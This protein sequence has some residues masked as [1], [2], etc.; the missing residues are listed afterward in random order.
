MSLDRRHVMSPNRKQ[1]R[2]QVREYINPAFRGSNHAAPSGYITKPKGAFM[3]SGSRR[4]MTWPTFSGVAVLLATLLVGA[5]GAK[6]DPKP[7]V[8]GP[9]GG[10]PKGWNAANEWALA[11]NYAET[12]SDPPLCPGLFGAAS[13]GDACRKIMLFQ[14]TNGRF[15]AQDLKGI[16]AVVAVEAPAGEPIVPG[17]R[18]AWRRCDLFITDQADSAQVRGMTTVLGAIIS[19]VGGPPFSKVEV[20]PMGVGITA[21]RVVVDVPD[22]LKVFLH[23]QESMNKV[24]PPNIENLGRTFRFLGPL[25]AY[26]ADTLY[27]AGADPAWNYVQRSG[28]LTTF[29][30]NS[31]VA[32][33]QATAAVKP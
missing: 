30:W 29:S 13:C 33:Q 15:R 31:D 21:N 11:G 19:G 5:T 3:K 6:P 1:R 22:R 32:Y 2:K 12:C 25:W 4:A 10:F 23:P 24:R 27:F 16:A 28:V 7:A 26:E 18:A 20:V 14:V 9:P 8:V 17:N